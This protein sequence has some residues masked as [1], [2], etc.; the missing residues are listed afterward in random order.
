MHRTAI[1]KD[2]GTLQPK[3]FSRAGFTLIEIAVVMAIIGMVMLLIIPRLPLSDQENLKISA[4]TLASTLRYMQERAATTASRRGFYIILAPGTETVKILEIGGD[5]NSKE[6]ADPLLLKSSVK[7]G[8]T[9][10][11]VR[12]PR[13]GK[14]VDGQLRVD[15]GVGGI[16]DFVTIHLRSAGGQFWTVMAFPSGGKVRALEG[17]IEDPP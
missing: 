1:G 17:Y 16:R 12:I 8:V 2:S 11:D 3:N 6:P 5:G 7:E 9:V 4:R 14:V 10:A 15:V 13:L